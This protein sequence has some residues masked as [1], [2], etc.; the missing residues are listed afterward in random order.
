MKPRIAICN[1]FG[2]DAD[3]LADFAHLNGFKGIDWSIDQNQSAKEFI[4]KMDKLKEFEVRFHCPFNGVDIAYAD[5]RA[6]KSMELLMKM[7][8]RIAM[9]GGNHMTIHIG[10]GHYSDKELDFNRAVENLTTLVQLG[11]ACGVSISLENLTTAWTNMPALFTTL[12]QRSGAGVTFDIGHAHTCEHLY[13]N[14]NI[15]EHFILPNRNNILNAHIYHT[16]VEEV[17]HVAP[18][19]L[20]E[21][22]DRLELLRGAESCKWWVIEL[23]TSRDIFLTRD[24][25]YRYLEFSLSPPIPALKRKRW[26]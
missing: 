14:G 2:Q 21:I 18:F 7:M 24:F 16:E 1:I 12:V 17:G 4:S 23:Q 5:V 11:A 10:F 6:E 22:Y 20:E 13:P 25:L 8:E 9:A 19:S 15:Y 3:R 26:F